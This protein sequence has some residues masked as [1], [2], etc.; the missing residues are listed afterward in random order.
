MSDDPHTSTTAAPSPA[1]VVTAANATTTHPAGSA[2]AG[3]GAGSSSLPGDRPEVI[4]G[5]A[6]AGGFVAAMILKRLGH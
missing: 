3:V 4:V 5:A 2:A 6:F 1:P